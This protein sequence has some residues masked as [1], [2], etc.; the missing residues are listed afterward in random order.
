MHSYNHGL[1]TS[2]KG[3]AIEFVKLT[4]LNVAPGAT[5]TSNLVVNDI[6]SGVINYARHTATGV[7]TVQLSLPYPPSLPICLCDMSNADGI[8]DL[9][10]PTYRSNSYNATTGQFIVQITNDDDVGAGVL[11][12]GGATD[13]L[14]L[15]L[16][17]RRYTT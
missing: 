15:V 16:A 2:S 5:S 4:G 6:R 8:T 14:H 1:V 17:F 11:A 12:A 10:H 3:A 13:E 7:I 9:L